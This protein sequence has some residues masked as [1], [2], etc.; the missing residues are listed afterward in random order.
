MGKDVI[1]IDLGGTHLRTALVRNN[2][3]ID[4][5]KRDTAKSKKLLLKGMAE[6]I[7][8]FINIYDGIRGIGV[9]SPGPLEN[10]K[11]LNTPNLP[12]RYFNLK[13]FLENKF[14]KK[15]VI[16][17]DANCVALAELKLGVKKHHFLV[18]TI[19]T[20]LG[21]GVIV[22]GK[23]FM[24]N[25]LGGEL[26]HIILDKGIDFEN[27]VASKALK[28]RTK[29]E[30]GNE[31]L[32]KDLIKL[33]SKGNVK[34]KKVLQ[35][36]STYLGQGIASLISVFDPDVIVLAGGAREAG[37]KFLNMIRK[38]TKKYSFLKGNYPIQWTKLEEPGVLGASLLMD[39]KNEK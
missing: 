25:G 10:G 22:H 9:A 8:H 11:L 24:G 3:I 5:K 35:E 14:H 18:L 7:Q 30:L 20:G 19:G 13:K 32:I 33:S 1:A 39:W 31:M 6:D 23:L 29:K 12:L 16:E 37:N 21:G 2:K 26:G 36:I 17:N 34:A 4:I 15:V 38:E 28:R 27:L